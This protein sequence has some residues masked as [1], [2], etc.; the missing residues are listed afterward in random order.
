[1]AELCSVGW[2]AEV[3]SNELGYLTE[4]ISKPTLKEWAWFIL[5]SCSKMQEERDK[6]WREQ[7]SKRSQHLMIWEVLRLSRLQRILKLGNLLSG[8]YVLKIRWRIW[9]HSLLW[10]RL[11]C[12]SRSQS[13]ILAEGR[14][15]DGA[16]QK[17][18]SCLTVGTLMTYTK[19]KG[20]E[21]G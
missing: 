16:I 12:N 1:M 15:R 8:K 4:E 6:L 7:A 5:T 2:K 18:P 14:P 11:G 21:T 17:E 3:V 13:T 10:K 19:A 9:L 20:T